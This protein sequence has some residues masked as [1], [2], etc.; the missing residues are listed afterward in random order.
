MKIRPLT[1]VLALAAAAA[2]APL[3]TGGAQAA[4]TTQVRVSDAYSYDDDAI[5]D[6][7]VCLDDVLLTDV[8]TRGTEGPFTVASGVHNVEIFP[9]GATDCAGE[10]YSDQDLDFQG[11]AATLFIYWGDN[12]LTAVVLPDDLS[13][14]QPGQA[15]LVLRNGATFYLAQAGGPVPPSS[16]TGVDLD[17]ED[18]GTVISDVVLGAQGTTTLLAGSHGAADLYAS[19][20]RFVLA[21]VT[22]DL[23]LAEGSVTVVSAYGGN[24]GGIGTYIDV[25]PVGLCEVPT[26]P[27]TESTTTTTE[28]TTTTTEPTT[29]TT[30][31]TTT[32][33]TPPTTTPPPAASPAI[34]VRGR[35]TF[36]G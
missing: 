15:R 36:T 1:A 19:D 33:V 35:P 12:G 16:V 32:T 26:I 13:C 4:T 17:T 18:D 29:T 11:A 34:A 8:S 7:S 27:T 10:A 31:A 14:T 20:A 23:V 21:P 2:V 6:H 5:F 9:G 30:E 24:D 25:I 22:Q 28:S 3:A